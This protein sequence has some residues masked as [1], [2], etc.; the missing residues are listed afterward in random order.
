[1]SRLH[2]GK[3][4]PGRKLWLLTLIAVI[5]LDFSNEKLYY[6]SKFITYLRMV[7]EKFKELEPN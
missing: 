1:M 3:L 7:F 5:Q 4:L 2:V 6:A